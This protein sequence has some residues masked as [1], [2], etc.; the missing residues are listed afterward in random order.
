MPC[1][2]KADLNVLAAFYIVALKIGKS[3]VTVPLSLLQQKN[4]WQTGKIPPLPYMGLVGETGGHVS[5]QGKVIGIGIY[6]CRQN[7]CNLTN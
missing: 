4:Y 1:S 6:I 3:H 2:V 7:N 5:K